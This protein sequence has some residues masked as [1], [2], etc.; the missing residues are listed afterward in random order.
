[1][2]KKGMSKSIAQAFNARALNKVGQQSQLRMFTLLQMQ[3]MRFSVVR[4]YTKTHEWIEFDTEKEL[5]KIGITEHAQKELGDIVHVDLPN[6][7]TS[8]SINES[9]ASVESVKTA[10]DIYQMVS[11]VV[12]E[13]NEDLNDDASLVN[14]D[15]EGRGWLMM[16]KLDE[17]KQLDDLLDEDS[18]K[19]LL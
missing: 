11:G 4:R 18:Y 14:E 13:I 9:I 12:E 7:G 17:K 10:A 8:F 2:M 5:A 3:T 1:M 6:E 19:N 15:A 16:V